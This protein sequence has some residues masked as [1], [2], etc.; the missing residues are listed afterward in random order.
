MKIITK[1]EDAY[2]QLHADPNIS[3]QMKRWLEFKAQEEGVDFD[4]RNDLPIS[5]PKQRN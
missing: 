1:I 2:A 5:D 3:A 4:S